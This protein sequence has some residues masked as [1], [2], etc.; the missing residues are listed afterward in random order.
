[1]ISFFSVNVG[2]CPNL[3][4]EVLFLLTS[5][6]D[7]GRSN[8]DK[9]LTFVKQ[10]AISY[11]I[12]QGT[13]IGVVTYG[14]DASVHVKFGEF[15]TLNDLSAAIHGIGYRPGLRRMDKALG[16]ASNSFFPTNG[17]AC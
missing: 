11:G 13:K 12:S 6:N 16:V 8:F 5:A 4:A 17:K 14:D 9:Q 1:M 10:M 3:N 15:T 7:V 2:S